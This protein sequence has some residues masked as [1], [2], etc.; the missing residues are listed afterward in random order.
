MELYKITSNDIKCNLINLNQ[1]VFEVTN[2]CNFRC[3]YC[4]YSGMYKGYSQLSTQFLSFGRVK[5]MLDY[6]LKLW[7][8]NQ[9]PVTKQPIFIG[10]F[11]GEP[12]LNFSLVKQIVQYVESHI[13]DGRNIVYSMTT[14][15]Y[16]LSEYMDFLVEKDFQLLISL[17]G[18]RKQNSFRKTKTGM[19]SFDKVFANILKLKDMY[20]NYFRRKVNFNAVFNRS[21]DSVPNCWKSTGMM[22]ASDTLPVATISLEKLGVMEAIIS[23]I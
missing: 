21:S 8:E 13:I 4:I 6:L 5:I 20:P 9:R 19:V 16:L 3:E 17:D 14:N 12:L 11:G 7:V 2:A 1:I 18:N 15:A 22:T 10:F 23:P